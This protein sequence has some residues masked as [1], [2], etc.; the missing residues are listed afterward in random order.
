MYGEITTVYDGH[1]PVL[2]DTNILKLSTP[3]SS[4]RAIALHWEEACVLAL[5]QWISAFFYTI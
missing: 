3:A 1:S 2:D 5:T 4:V